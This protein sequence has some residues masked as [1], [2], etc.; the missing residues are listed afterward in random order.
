MNGGKSPPHPE[1][2]HP[3]APYDP[4]RL[5]PRFFEFRPPENFQR[6]RP[7]ISDVLRAIKKKTTRSVALVAAVT[8]PGGYG[9]TAIAEEIASDPLLR[10][11]FHGGIY[12]LQFGLRFGNDGTDLQGYINSQEAISRMVD[13]QF[14]DIDTKS[15]DLSTP[16]KLFDVLPD[17]KILIIADDI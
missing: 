2:P 14:P 5:P 8:G 12:W 10:R 17:D 9:K 7:E 13:S 3:K 16:E 4:N 1:D 15:F 11:R 6:K